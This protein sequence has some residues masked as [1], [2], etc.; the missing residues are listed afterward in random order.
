MNFAESLEWGA[1]ITV[2]ALFT[3]LF[4]W[5]ML[6]MILTVGWTPILIVGVIV[7]AP[8]WIGLIIWYI[9]NRQSN[10]LKAGSE[11]GKE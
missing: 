3:A 1:I 7:S 9:S 11:K 6:Y 8:Y 2:G 4:G 5:I 10:M